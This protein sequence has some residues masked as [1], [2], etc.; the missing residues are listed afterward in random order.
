LGTFLAPDGV[1]PIT[2]ASQGGGGGEITYQGTLTETGSSTGPNQAQF[3][4][5]GGT[6]S[7]F[8]DP[9]ADAN[10]VTG[11][12]YAG[13]GDAVQILSGTVAPGDISSFAI[14]PNA[15]VAL[16][17]HTVNGDNQHGVLTVTGSGGGQITIGSLSW[18]SD[19]IRIEGDPSALLVSMFFNTSFI[20]PFRQTDPS[21]A[22]VGQT[23]F[24]SNVNGTAIN[25]LLSPT[26][27]CRDENGNIRVAPCDFH[28]QADATGSF[29]AV[30]VPEPGSLAL[31][32]I[33]LAAVGWLR[34]RTK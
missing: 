4:S 30:A 3:I 12:G 23:P 2:L 27:T 21:N 22:V 25:G 6:F 28:F 14:G 15:P 17:S 20:T 7:L 29:A 11:A 19:Y 16:D 26:A 13:T 34:R 9:T 32:G 33:G 5:T 31:L 10:A 1:T 24:Y 18:N 8:W